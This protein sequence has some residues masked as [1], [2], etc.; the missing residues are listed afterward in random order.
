LDPAAR[1]IDEA[2][3]PGPPLSVAYV[4]PFWPPDRHANG[5]VMYLNE[6]TMTV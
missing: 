1:D 6:I 4:C 5:I 2:T 3:I